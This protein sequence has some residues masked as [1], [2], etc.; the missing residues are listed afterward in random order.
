VLCRARDQQPVLRVPAE[1]VR[2]RSR[3]RVAEPACRRCCP[4]RVTGTRARSHLPGLSFPTPFL[5][6]RTAPAPH[7][8]AILRPRQGPGRGTASAPPPRE[9]DRCWAPPRFLLC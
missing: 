1:L 7:H 9:P 4:H 6:Q 2:L 8:L 5:P 3:R